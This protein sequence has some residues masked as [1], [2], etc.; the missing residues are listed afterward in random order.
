[1]HNPFQMIFDAAIWDNSNK[2]SQ[3]ESQTVIGAGILMFGTI[4]FV[5]CPDAV[6]D[7]GVAD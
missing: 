2:I 7:G 4:N 5:V 6:C 1:M 3:Q